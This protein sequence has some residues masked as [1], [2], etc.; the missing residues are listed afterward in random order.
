[1]ARRS[2][3]QRK[4]IDCKATEVAQAFIDG[5][6]SETEARRQ[7]AG[8]AWE[9]GSA[10]GPVWAMS[11][12]ERESDTQVNEDIV[13]QLHELIAR[14]ILVDDGRG[15]DIARIAAGNSLCGW[16][17]LL[18]K[19][20][21]AS[22]RRAS[23]RHYNRLVGAVN[24][25]GDDGVDASVEEVLDHIRETGQTAVACGTHPVL[26][27]ES[28]LDADTVESLIENYEAAARGRA[29]ERRVH[30]RA[31]AVRA[32]FGLREPARI[33]HAPNRKRLLD[34]ILSNP[35]IPRK[36]AAGVPTGLDPDDEAQLAE[37]WED[38]PEDDI[39]DLADLDPRV[40]YAL[41]VSALTPIRPPS[42]Q[43]MFDLVA[44][45]AAKISSRDVAVRLVSAW[46]S[47]RS[48]VSGRSV[49]CA[50]TRER[51]R[52]AWALAANDA[53][54]AGYVQLGHTADEVSMSIEDL[55]KTVDK[56]AATRVA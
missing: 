44:K 41:A 20:A 39:D 8:L 40:S 16:T 29:E 2:S 27:G 28:M 47:C 18:A 7:I 23:F 5:K 45:V 12:R 11:A 56:S 31:D 4:Q 46:A 52:E 13:V 51:D 15:L 35:G 14:K 19:A 50:R 32:A 36:C 9:S 24:G 22:E 42:K 48:E 30:L 3:E 33:I 34:L 38:W 53:I 49:K 43:Q 10:G 25:G 26:P 54:S 1:M 17:W 37:V 55:L 21:A 6:I